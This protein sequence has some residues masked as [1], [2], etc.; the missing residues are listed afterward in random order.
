MHKSSRYVHLCKYITEERRLD[1][2]KGIAGAKGCKL[3]DDP[4][5]LAF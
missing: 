5:V 3:V 4:E 2:V 1:D